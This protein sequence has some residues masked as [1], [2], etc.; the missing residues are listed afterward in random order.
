MEKFFIVMNKTLSSK[1]FRVVL[2]LLLIGFLSYKGFKKNT[3]NPDKFDKILE[4]VKKDKKNSI[5]IGIAKI[6]NKKNINTKKD[7]TSTAIK[8]EITP[9][10]QEI[11]DNIKNRELTEKFDKITNVLLKMKTLEGVYQDRLKNKKLNYKRTIK[12]GDVIYHLNTGIVSNDIAKNVTD[13]NSTTHSFMEIIKGDFISER[14]VG[15]K[16]GDK[17]EYTYQELLD[18]LPEDTRKVIDNS[19]MKRTSKDGD[20]TFEEAMKDIKI[21]YEVKV[22]DFISKDLIDK[23]E[24]TA[25]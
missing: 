21:K 12:Y 4:Q 22:L 15:K 5:S 17:I 3:V 10:R 13:P 19:V 7:N 14:L 23:L 16:I 24:L 6:Q 11:V 25:M 20:K 2:T 18:S 9:E 8:K 1:A